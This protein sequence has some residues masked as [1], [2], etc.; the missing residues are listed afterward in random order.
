MFHEMFFHEMFHA[1]E[2]NITLPIA[3]KSSLGG[4]RP[5][6]RRSNKVLASRETGV[7]E[8]VDDDLRNRLSIADSAFGLRQCEH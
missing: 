5:L 1:T 8:S 7:I 3:W 2:R 6:L 4:L